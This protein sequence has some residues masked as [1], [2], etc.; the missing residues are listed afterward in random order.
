MV[1]HEYQYEAFRRNNK[2]DIYFFMTVSAGRA[3]VSTAM[4]E[5]SA[6]DTVEGSLVVSVAGVSSVSL[7]L[8]E[9]IIPAIARIIN[10]FFI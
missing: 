5:V 1:P 7:S 4:V 3:G 10:N 9:T 2:K 8:Q 6:G